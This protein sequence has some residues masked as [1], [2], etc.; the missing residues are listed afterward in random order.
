MEVPMGKMVLTKFGC[1]YAAALSWRAYDAL[2][3]RYP[4]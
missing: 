3:M 1:V 4:L 2:M